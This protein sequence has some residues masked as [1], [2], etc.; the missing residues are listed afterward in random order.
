MSKARKVTK[1]V[2]VYETV[3]CGHKGCTRG[4][5]RCG[6]C[7]EFHELCLDHE[8]EELQER[9]YCTDPTCQ[10]WDHSECD[11]YAGE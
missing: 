6:E 7:G 9:M 2:I 1:N 10:G 11:P 3:P 8:T 5:E 4:V